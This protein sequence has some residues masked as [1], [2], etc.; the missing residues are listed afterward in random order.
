[1]RVIHD[2]RTEWSLEIEC[3]GCKSTLEIIEEDVKYGQFGAMGDYEWEL[4]V[5]CPVCEADTR[6]FK[7]PNFVERNTERP[8]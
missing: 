3:S 6:N 8:R 7:A 1:M 5:H 2:A 4:Y